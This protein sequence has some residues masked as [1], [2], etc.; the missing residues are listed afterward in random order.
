VRERDGLAMSSRNV[1]LTPAS[2][3][4]CS[5]P[6]AQGRARRVAETAAATPPSIAARSAPPSAPWRVLANHARPGDYAAVVDPHTFQPPIDVAPPR[7]VLLL[8]AVRSS[9]RLI[10]NVPSPRIQPM[11][12]PSPP[13]SRRREGKHMKSGLAKVPSPPGVHCSITLAVCEA[14]GVARAVV[15]VGC[16][17]SR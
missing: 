8:V 16:G 15:V 11:N 1:R 17:A 10:D 12:G 13:S 14:A 5:V 4:G 9:A 7:H 2:A 6:R 3:P